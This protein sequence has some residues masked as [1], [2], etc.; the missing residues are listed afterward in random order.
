MASLG[1]E[2][3]RLAA[4]ACHPH[5]RVRAL[6]RLGN[7]VAGRQANVFAGVAGERRLGQATQRDA[8]ALFPHGALVV[9]VDAERVEF[10][11]GGSFAGAELDP[12]AGEQVKGRD[13]FGYPGRV[14]DRRNGVHDPVSESDAAGAL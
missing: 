9:G 11:G 2:V 8:Q 4:A 5:R 3:D 10:R 7:D 6:D 1:G 13:P 12:A 14:V